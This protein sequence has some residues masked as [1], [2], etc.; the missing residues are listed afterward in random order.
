MR[1]IPYVENNKTQV[2]SNQQKQPIAASFTNS[3]I[4]DKSV[5]MNDLNDLELRL[6]IFF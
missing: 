5:N 6:L 4:N 3:K 1:E 2:T